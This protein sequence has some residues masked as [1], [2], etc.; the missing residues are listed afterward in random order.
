MRG[1][2]HLFYTYVLS[3]GFGG[4]TVPSY[5]CTFVFSYRTLYQLAQHLPRSFFKAFLLFQ[6]DNS[7]WFLEEY[8]IKRPYLNKNRNLILGFHSKNANEPQH[9]KTNKV[10]VRPVKTRI[11]LGI[12]PVWSE[13]PLCAQW[14]AKGP[15]FLHA[16]DARASCY[17]YY[18]RA[19][20]CCACSRCRT[21]GLYLYFLFFIYLPFLMSC[22]LGDGWT[23]LKYCSFSC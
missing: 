15:R 19:R 18:S 21:S 3:S 2:I 11:S 14:V 20:A 13:S 16:D 7:D 9:D 6:Y 5:I 17:F 22:L 10:S 12:C 1:R 8:P 4:H 23:W